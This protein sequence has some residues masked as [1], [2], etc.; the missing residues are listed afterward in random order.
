MEHFLPYQKI[1]MSQSS[2]ISALPCEPVSLKE[3]RKEKNAGHLAAIRLQ[4]LPYGEP[5]ELR[6]RK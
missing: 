2:A 3:L 5:Q 4:S 6:M 1:R